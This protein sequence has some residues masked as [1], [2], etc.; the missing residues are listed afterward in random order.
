[1][2]IAGDGRTTVE[3]FSAIDDQSAKKRAI[4]AAQ[5]ISVALWHGDQLVARWTR[6][7]RSFLAS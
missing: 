5:G 6:R 7:G 4:V 1:M 3:R 2:D